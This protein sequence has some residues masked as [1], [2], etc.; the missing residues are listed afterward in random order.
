VNAYVTSA[1]GVVVFDL[2]K[3]MRVCSFGVRLWMHV[4]RDLKADYWAVVRCRAAIIRQVAVIDGF[5]GAAASR[6]RC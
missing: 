5:L 4:I 1:L 2:D 3:L 6:S